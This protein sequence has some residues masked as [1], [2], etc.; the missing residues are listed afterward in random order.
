LQNQ[1]KT[2]QN[3]FP[4]LQK[5]AKSNQKLHTHNE[6]SM[7]KQANFS[8][9]SKISQNPT[10]NSQNSVQNSKKSIPNQTPKDQAERIISHLQKS[11][12]KQ[13]A[14]KMRKTCSQARARKQS[15][16]TSDLN[17]SV[18]ERREKTRVGRKIYTQ[19]MTIEIECS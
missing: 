8:Q 13:E 17:S 12:Q 19:L 11:H 1:V 3:F 7:Q 6:S 14:K 9:N 15:Q 4:E 16:K 2:P 18:L 10:K 5:F